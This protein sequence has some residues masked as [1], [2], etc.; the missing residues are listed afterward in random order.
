MRIGF[1]AIMAS[2]ATHQLLKIGH[3]YRWVFDAAVGRMAG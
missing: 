3:G 1:G 2:L